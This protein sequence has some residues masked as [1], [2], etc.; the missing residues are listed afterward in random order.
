MT[1]GGGAP[2]DGVYLQNALMYGTLIYNATASGISI[3]HGTHH[4]YIDNLYYV[5]SAGG[6][7]V[8]SVKDSSATTPDIEDVFVTHNYF[9]ISS[10]AF[11]I[12]AGNFANYNEISKVI[13][14]NF[15]SG[16]SGSL[17]ATVNSGG[18][19]VSG[20]T[21]VN[22]ELGTTS[23]SNLGNYANGAAQP[24]I[25]Y[26]GSCSVLPTA[27][28]QLREHPAFVKNVVASDNVVDLQ[29]NGGT[30]TSCAMTALST[31]LTCASGSF[32][33][34]QQG[35]H[36]SV[37]GAGS[38]GGPLGDTVIT[39]YVNSSTLTLNRPA[40]VTVTSA[41]ATF[42]YTP[43]GIFSFGQNTEGGGFWRNKTNLLG[44]AGCGPSNYIE[45][46]NS[47]YNATFEDNVIKTVPPGTVS[48]EQS[49]GI[50][51]NGA[52][53]TLVKNNT[54]D[55]VEVVV[56]SDNYPGSA[57]DV[58]DSNHVGSLS[59]SLNGGTHLGSTINNISFLDNT[60]ACG[61]FV[62]GVSSDC[63]NGGT[64]LFISNFRPT[65][66][67]GIG[68]Q[69]VNAIDIE[70]NNF[71][72]NWEYGVLNQNPITNTRVCGNTYDQQ[73]Q[74]PAGIQATSSCDQAAPG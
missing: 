19:V 72:G 35:Q 16:C 15:G 5:D 73:I 11:V 4:V 52:S 10:S 69:G 20:V 53:N 67:S 18:A 56:E 59:L 13:V 48:I 58:I 26:S 44:G 61:G 32:T 63:S 45:A 55:G 36:I 50:L 28:L 64:G 62:T 42:S 54:V 33:P 1:I 7:D 8:I 40:V 17:S 25:T 46:S 66:T 49:C 65:A 51:L 23:F 43:F 21:L 29:G 60:V 2:T 3:T 68:L 70:G 37:A 27:V 9:N 57:Y 30:A 22:G 12:E 14:T 38:G 31:T 41:V 34:Q 74:T 24:T 6:Q 47:I 39:T 71:V